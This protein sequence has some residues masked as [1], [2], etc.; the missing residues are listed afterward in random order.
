[1]ETKKTELL[2]RIK[3]LKEKMEEF[4]ENIDLLESELKELEEKEKEVEVS[5]TGVILNSENPDKRSEK[6]YFDRG[7]FAMNFEDM[8]K[9]FTYFETEKQAKQ[10][11]LRIEGQEFIRRCAMLWNIE[12]DWRK[13]NKIEQFCLDYD[14][15]NGDLGT[16]TFIGYT[17]CG[18]IYFDTREL[19]EKCIAELKKKYNEEQIKIIF[20]V[21]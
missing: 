7:M 5:A 9:S 1:M 21:K 17:I 3:D 4:S 18:A 12:H 10:E 11:A 6:W 8:G 15:A 19:T 16:G 13:K 14:T 20:G 2:R